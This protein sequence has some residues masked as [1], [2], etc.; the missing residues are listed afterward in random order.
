MTNEHK[1][2]RLLNAAKHWQNDRVFAEGCIS[3]CLC[4]AFWYVDGPGWFAVLA[5]AALTE[6]EHGM[7][8]ETEQS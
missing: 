6:V 1:A 7:G 3:E 2:D 5:S 4:E 8:F